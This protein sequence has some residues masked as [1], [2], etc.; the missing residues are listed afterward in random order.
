MHKLPSRSVMQCTRVYD[1]TF[2]IMLTPYSLLEQ[3][4]DGGRSI[5]LHVYH[6]CSE[7]LSQQPLKLDVVYAHDV[8]TY[9]Q[10]VAL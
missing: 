4:F 7:E 3:K 2:E 6:G 9:C 10:R 5:P 8:E 1:S